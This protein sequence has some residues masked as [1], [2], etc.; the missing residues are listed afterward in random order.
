[1][2][3]DVRRRL[4]A[5]LVLLVTVPGVVGAQTVDPSV[6][7]DTPALRAG[8]S[9]LLVLLFG[10]AILHRYEGSIDRSIDA[11]TD[12]PLLSVVYG[13]MA[14]IMV[15]FTGIGF[16]S[17]VA[18]V[19]VDGPPISAV[20]MVVLVAALFGLGG[21]GFV[22]VGTWL[23]TLQGDRRPWYGLVV[24]AVI[25]S[26]AWLLLPLLGGVLA[27]G[28]VVSAGIGGLTRNW[29]HDERT[30]EGRTDG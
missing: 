19:N 8:T 4:T 26:L 3:S 30:G 20:G 12:R 29:V 6:V 5:G 11:M 15:T 18:R 1:M 21:L 7:V 28:L 25:S 13:A 23:T 14:H 16:L 24:G 17:Q 2:Q 27:W 10:G 22:V 9:F